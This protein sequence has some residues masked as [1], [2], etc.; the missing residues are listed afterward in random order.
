MQKKSKEF[1]DHGGRWEVGF[2]SQSS[3]GQRGRK[4]RKRGERVELPT[5]C[6]ETNGSQSGGA[7][8]QECYRL[9]DGSRLWWRRA[10]WLGSPTMLVALRTSWDPSISRR[11]GSR[12]PMI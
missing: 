5:A 6:W 10:G 4:E 12:T 8:E 2:P 3:W 1:R 7:G 11:E 9:P